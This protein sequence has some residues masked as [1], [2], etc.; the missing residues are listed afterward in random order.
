L[1]FNVP[2]HEL[3]PYRAGILLKS[4][5][6]GAALGCRMAAPL[7]RKKNKSKTFAITSRTYKKKPK[8]LPG[9]KLFPGEIVFCVFFVPFCGYQSCFFGSTAVFRIKLTTDLVFAVIRVHL[10]PSVVHFFAVL[11]ARRVAARDVFL[12]QKTRN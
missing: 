8:H 1:F 10:C 9:E 2:W 6:Q 5:S 11:C 4:F 12:A 3:R 7:G